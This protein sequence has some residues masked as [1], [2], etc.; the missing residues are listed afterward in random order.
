MA[1]AL[2]RAIALLTDGLPVDWEGLLEDAVDG[3]ERSLIEELRGLA[4]LDSEFL[5]ATVAPAVQ[6]VGVSAPGTSAARRWGHLELLEEIGRGTYGSVY[7]AWDTRLAREVALKLLEDDEGGRSLEEARRLARIAHPNVVAVY[8]ADRIEGRVGLWMELLR[9][10]TLDQILEAQGPFSA[11]EAVGIA[12]EVCGAVAAIHAAGLLHRDI[13]AQNVMREPGGRLV[14]MDMGASIEP[15]LDDVAVRSLMGTP[16]YMAPELFEGARPSVASDVYA[17]GVLLYRLVTA[18]FP[19][20]A[21]TIGDVRLAHAEARQRPIREVRPDLPARFVGVVERCLAHDAA[22][23]YSS[24]ADIET[25][26]KATDPSAPPS[27]PRSFWVPVAACAIAIAAAAIVFSRPPNKISAHLTDDQIKVARAFEELAGTLASRGDWREAAAQ[28]ER[29]GQIYRINL[30]PDAPLVAQALLNA[31]FAWKEAGE[32]NKARANYELAIRKFETSYA[33][34]PQLEVANAGLALLQQVS[35]RYDEA[36]RL[37]Q[38]ALA[39]R[40]RMFFD[41]SGTHKGIADRMRGRLAELGS[42]YRLDQ[43][44]DGDGLPDLLEAVVGLNPRSRDSNGNG[45]EDGDEDWDGDG[46]TNA[47]EFGLV[48]DPSK[49]IAH[50]GATDPEREGFQQ[51]ANRPFVGTAT[52]RSAAGPSWK[53]PSVGLSMYFLPLTSAQRAT[54]LTRGWRLMTRGHV[55]AG[56]AFSSIDLASEGPR[57]DVD[58]I[59]R[60]E[61]VDIQLNTSAVPYEGMRTAVPGDGWPLTELEYDPRSKSARVAI[62][63][64]VANPTPYRGYYQFQEGLGLFFGSSSEIVNV[65]RGDAD[66]NLVMFTIR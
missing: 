46:V 60:T 10:R 65:P 2:N 25:G 39:M 57:F 14:L 59:H 27:R 1:E 40:A 47:L 6:T 62:A 23:R 42:V 64:V 4:Q 54:A 15:G 24:V 16:L 55:P 36:E 50:Y 8:G 43:D 32:I 51:P 38:T 17:I 45:I 30:S 37:L 26:L 11:R 12:V 35:G 33:V 56:I 58:V 5:A 9:G 49:I 3:H 29:A 13:K 61:S 22:A 63:G 66:F 19:M 21:R 52:P 20:D 28:Y 31:G 48:I 34:H 44:D 18:E 41:A 7:R 53:V